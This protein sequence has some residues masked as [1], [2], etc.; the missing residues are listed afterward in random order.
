M[1]ESVYESFP[2]AASKENAVRLGLGTHLGSFSE[3]DSRQYIEAVSFAVRNGITTIDTAINY[4][5][6]R[7]EKDV[8]KAI[9]NLI[10]SD[11]IQRD[12][13][14][15]ASK[16]GLLFGDITRGLN[17]SRYLHEVLEPTGIRLDDFCEYD[18]LYQTLNPDFF[19]YALHI[20]LQNLGV[21][22]IDVHYIHLPEITRAQL[23]EAEFYQRLAALFAWYEEKV[24]QG[25]IRFYGLAFEM[26]CMEPGEEKWFIDIEKVCQIAEKISGRDSHLKYV[27]LPYNMDCPYA[28]TVPNQRYGKE[29]TS[30]R[31]SLIK[32]ARK[33]GMHVTGSMPMCSGKGFEQHT[34]K[35]MITFALDGVDTVNIGSKNVKHI[36]EILD[37]VRA[38]A[39]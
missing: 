27:Q 10:S 22:T 37:I 4:R 29:D 17:P 1:K 19:E 21:S 32:A 3:E 8:G 23:T 20:S 5:G 30:E 6:M 39:Q 28:T 31:V 33:L 12:D 38:K 16:A 24:K 2:N 11:E 36:Q 35:E 25:K 15:I 14:V 26:L 13:I 9:N 18:G 34:L 7:S